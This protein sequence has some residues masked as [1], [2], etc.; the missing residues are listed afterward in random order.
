MAGAGQ[1]QSSAKMLTCLLQKVLKSKNFT[2]D[3]HNFIH[4]KGTANGTGANFANMYMGR[5]QDT[6]VYCTDWPH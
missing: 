1:I 2:F 4:V 6:F 3:N 5:F